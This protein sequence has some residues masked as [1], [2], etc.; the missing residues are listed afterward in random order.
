MKK[1]EKVLGQLQHK[2]VGSNVNFKVYIVEDFYFSFSV[3][4]IASPRCEATVPS[5]VNKF[6]LLFPFLPRNTYPVPQVRRWTKHVDFME[7][8]KGL[9]MNNSPFNLSVELRSTTRPHPPSRSAPPS[10][11]QLSLQV[12]KGISSCD[13]RKSV[14]QDFQGTGA[15]QEYTSQVGLY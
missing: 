8:C 5:Y 15:D 4:A 14:T 2:E 10:S 6:L 13:H 9:E 12:L 7:G 1:K 11:T 3:H